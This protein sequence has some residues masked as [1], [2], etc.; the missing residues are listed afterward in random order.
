M[1]K[2]ASL[3]AI[4][5]LAV[6][7]TS[8]AVP[9]LYSTGGAVDTYDTKYT[10]VDLDG[11]ETGLKSLVADLS[12]S[13]SSRPELNT[14]WTGSTG[15][16]ISPYIEGDPTNAWWSDSPAFTRENFIFR[17]LIG[18]SGSGEVSFSI[19]SDNEARVFVGSLDAT[20]IP[21]TFGEF[22]YQTIVPV[23]LNVTAGQYIYFQVFNKADG[24]FPEGN[25]V[26]LLIRPN[27]INPNEFTPVPEGGAT[28]LLLGLGVVGVGVARRYLA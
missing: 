28:A 18:G 17:T 10:L 16:W 3:L 23:T 6:T 2:V 9:I 7:S 13:T 20:A 22:A 14:Y 21:L 4:V 25:P 5:L 15:E 24:S 12:D 26:G 27:V 1:E 19:S 8:E 11:I